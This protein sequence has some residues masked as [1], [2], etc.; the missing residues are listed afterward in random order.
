MDTEKAGPPA[1]YGAPPGYP[2]PPAGYP[3]P[4]P[5]YLPPA[6]GDGPQPAGYRTPDNEGPAARTPAS[7][8]ANI[9]NS[10]LLGFAPWIALSIL[11]GPGRIELAAAV[12]LA[13]S[14]LVVA[15]D[16][17]RGRSLKLLSCVDVISFAA[18]LIIGLLLSDSAR[19][20]LETWFGEISNIILV[21]VAAASMLARRPF[22]LQ[23]A[24][25]EVSPEYWT[26]PLFIRI[27]YVITGAWCLSFLVAA[28]AG[29][30][31]DAVLHN[32]NNL[33]T[34]WVIQIGAYLL[35]ARFTEWY[36]DYATARAAAV[37]GRP[38]A[39]APS[40]A[41]LLIPLTGY[42]MPAGIVALCV[43]AGPWWLGVGL[44]VAGVV[45]TGQLRTQLTDNSAA[46][47]YPG[48]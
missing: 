35:A 46:A 20:W 36:P 39:G 19:S 43:D 5:G 24:K 17:F 47:T 26:S 33:W 42:L 48:R 9:L 32:N 38:T 14:V 31:G 34:G 7:A 16:R 37:A 25:E 40:V 4:P 11:E 23:Y 21:V 13:M 15:I 12:A 30:Y 45:L 44:I 18:L 29:F 10:P 27:N 8:V 1:P 2:L 6:A 41:G 3:A 28:A 22:T